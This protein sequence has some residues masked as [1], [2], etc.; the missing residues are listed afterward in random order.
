MGQGA[1]NL[2]KKIKDD[3]SWL[4]GKMSEGW[5]SVKSFGKK[6]YEQIKNVPVLGKIAEGIEKYT[7]I[8][9]AATASLKGI[10]AL[11]TGSSKLLQ[12]DVK[13]AVSTA[14]SFGRD[15][16]NTNNPLIEAGKKIPVLGGL[17][18]KIDSVAKNI[19]IYGGMSVNTMRS[20]GN[21]GLNAVDAFKEDD[22][23]GGFKNLA[24]GGAGY[25]ST[26]SGTAGMAGK[27]LDKVL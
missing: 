6:T 5:E 19:P 8:G 1:S 3:M 23:K 26:R 22:I 9:M 27:A 4:G 2:G 16:L 7:P 12:G 10:D 13:G 15:A 11:A 20:I 21:S 17:V 25:L 14:T 24:K 18:S